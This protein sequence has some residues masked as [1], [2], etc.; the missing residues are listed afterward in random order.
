MLMTVWDEDACSDDVV[1]TARV[2]LDPI[3][4]SGNFKDWIEIEYEG[5]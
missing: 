4:K 2:S 5:K 3:M 1:G